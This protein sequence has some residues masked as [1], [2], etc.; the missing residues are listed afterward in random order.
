[1]YG[2]NS[3][4]DS[5]NSLGLKVGIRTKKCRL[6][7]FQFIALCIKFVCVTIKHVNN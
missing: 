1:M 6:R 2:F 4:L 3:D 5:C 7:Y